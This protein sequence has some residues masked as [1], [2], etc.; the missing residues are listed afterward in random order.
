MSITSAIVFYMVI[1]ALT[2]FIINPLWQ[3]SQEEAGEIVPGTPASA[4]VDVMFRRKAL[5]TT[6][7]ATAVF[8]VLYAVIEIPLVTLEDV[9][10]I[11]PPSER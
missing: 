10:W 2:F 8:V 3:T 7:W 1:W 11:V 4:P 9:S 6:V 5:W